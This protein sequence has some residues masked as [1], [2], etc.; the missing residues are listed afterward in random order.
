MTRAGAGNNQVDVFI[1]YARADRERAESVAEALRDGGFLVWL[2]SSLKAGEYWDD[3]IETALREAKSV[4]VLW[5]KESVRSHWVKT[6]AEQAR[7]RGVLVP[8][9]IEAVKIPYG[10][11]R[12]HTADL[13]TW[14]T[15]T[16][17]AGIEELLAGVARLSHKSGSTEMPV[18]TRTRHVWPNVALAFILPLATAI[19]LASLHRHPTQ[20]SL[21][22]AT[23][24]VGLTP[25]RVQEFSDLI[26]VSEVQAS[27]LERLDI[28]RSRT[29]A[30]QTLTSAG[31]E[32]HTIVLRRVG[33]RG[34]ASITIAP[35]T[36]SLTSR[37]TLAWAAGPGKFRIDADT[38]AP[39]RLS[40]AGPIETNVPPK[41]VAMTDFDFPKPMLLYPAQHGIDLGFTLERGEDDVLAAPLPV[42]DLAFT[43]LEERDEAGG[44]TAI[45]KRSTLMS[46]SLQVPSESIAVSRDQDLKLEHVSG[47][48]TRIRLNSNNIQVQFRGEVGAI[49]TCAG[50][51][52][53]NLASTW[54]GI[55]W[56]DYRTTAIA[57]VSA[58]MAVVVVILSRGTLRLGAVRA[59]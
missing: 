13:T 42:K 4:V 11:G 47:V 34:K 22:V 24:A 10:F 43:T 51:V 32:L 52:C 21:D 56:S 46:G 36:L 15:G 38:N 58:Y 57:L 33:S 14:R 45:R 18:A 40:I 37:T 44:R 54:L 28:P 50:G 35:L 16:S 5:S 25:A 53:R 19:L 31:D 26:L 1:S 48:V 17:H 27:K 23:E 3:S 59:K 30:G 29:F 12:I 8:A 9:R 49:S 55:L 2:D 7:Q 6:E 41:P 20:V 39:V